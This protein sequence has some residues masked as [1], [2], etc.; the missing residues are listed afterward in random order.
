MNKIK[1]N[2][3]EIEVESGRNINISGNSV[4][5][6]NEIIEIGNGRNFNFGNTSVKIYIESDVPV[7]IDGD[8]NGSIDSKG[9]VSCHDV[10]GN[11]KAEDINCGDVMGNV[12]GTTVRKK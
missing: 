9:N 12:L 2:G 3:I 4:I 11:I 8:V 6:G 1:I 10:K 7:N 5:V